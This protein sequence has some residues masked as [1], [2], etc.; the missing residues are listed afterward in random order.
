[1][2]S[3]TLGTAA[4]AAFPVARHRVPVSAVINIV[5][6]MIRQRLNIIRPEIIFVSVDP[7]LKLNGLIR[8][9]GLLMFR[10]VVLS[11][12]DLMI[13]LTRTRSMPLLLK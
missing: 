10:F 13:L 3:V 9:M 1:M 2:S 8:A 6:L 7:A 4:M 12:R 5:M 11:K